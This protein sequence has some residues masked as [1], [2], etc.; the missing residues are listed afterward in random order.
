M[1]VDPRTVTEKHDFHAQK[2][3]I[4]FDLNILSISNNNTFMALNNGI[5]KYLQD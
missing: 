4:K 2:F 3:G 1:G 5:H